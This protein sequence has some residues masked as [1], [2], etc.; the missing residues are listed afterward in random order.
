MFT[1]LIEATGRI[2]AIARSE[3]GGRVRLR[4][5]LGA[6]LRPGDS[7]AVNGV[8]LTVTRQDAETVT[9]DLAPVTM[10]VTTFGGMRDGRLVNLERPLRADARLG[11]HFVLGHVDA[12]SRILSFEDDGDSAWLAIEVPP[13]LESLV[14]PKGSI[15]I[16]GISLTIASLAPGRL[17]VQIVPFTR[18]HTALA[19]A[20]PGDAVN[21]E[22][23]VLGKYVAR[24]LSADS[25][26]VP[27]YPGQTS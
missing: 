6:E 15:A 1:G 23:D 20:L 8:C 22:A 7:L 2:E 3:R 25:D 27:S 18:A 5:P 11:G 19:E 24:L 10:A 14:I 21:L 12:T 26:R 16:D 9:A 17:A 13:A 4:T